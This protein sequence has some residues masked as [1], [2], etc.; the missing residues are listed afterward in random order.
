MALSQ[1]LDLR[2]SQSLVMTPQLQQAIKL[3][4]LSNLELS[5]YVEGELEQNPAARARRL[6]VRRRRRQR[7]SDAGAE[8][9]GS[10][11]APRWAGVNSPDQQDTGRRSMPPQRQL[12]THELTTSDRW[13]AG[14]CRSTPI[15]RRLDQRR[16]ADGAS[17]GE[18][19]GDWSSRGGGGDF[20]DGDFDLEQTL[21]GDLSLREHLIGQIERRS[22]RSGATG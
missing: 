1:R 15:S 8:R 6:G 7:L 11:A 2:Q 12:D 16:A 13:P 4:Q 14:D 5:D 9:R 19:F 17:S 3:L 18:A 22:A 20:E 10:Q 21:S